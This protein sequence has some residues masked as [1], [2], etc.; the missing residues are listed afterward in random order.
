[1]P[2][3]RSMAA[4]LIAV[5]LGFAGSFAAQ[6]DSTTT[7]KNPPPPPA[8]VSAPAGAPAEKATAASIAPQ[9][10][11]HSAHIGHDVCKTHHN[12]PQCS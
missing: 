7:T 11:G 4:A 2:G 10:I 9:M 5:S 3:K 6:Q 1:M 12:L 8:S